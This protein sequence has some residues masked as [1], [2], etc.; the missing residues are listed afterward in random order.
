MDQT[1]F[2][3]QST[4][5]STLSRFLGTSESIF[6]TI[7]MILMM[8][9]ALKL[10]DS[11][12]KMEYWN[13]FNYYWDPFYKYLCQKIFNED[14]KFSKKVIINE[15][16]ENKEINQ[17][18]KAFYWYLSSQIDLK[19]ETPLRYSSS[20]DLCLAENDELL[21]S[22]FNKTLMGNISKSF[23]F[24]GHQINY[25]MGSELITIYGLEKERKRENNIIY[26]DTDYYTGQSMDIIDNLCNHVM[27][28]YA[29]YK[30]G[31][32]WEQKLYL[33]RY[34]RWESSLSRNKRHLKS[35]ILKKDQKERLIED[36]N[37]F[38]CSEDWYNDRD[39]P[40]R[41]GYLLY[42]YPGTGKTSFFKGL[43]NQLNRHIHCLNLNE[44]SSDAELID[45]LKDID[46]QKTILVI[47]D[48]DCLSNLVKDRDESN[49]VI[50]K[51]N[52]QGGHDDMD[53]CPTVTPVPAPIKIE[54]CGTGQSQILD[55]NKTHTSKSKL[56]L[57]GLLNVLDGVFSTDGRIIIMTSNYPEVLDKALIRPGRID[58][59]E[60]FGRCDYF[61]ICQLFKTFYD[62]SGT[63][64]EDKY[65]SLKD[66]QEDKYSPA[67]ITGIF[68]KHRKDPQKSLEELI[69][70]INQDDEFYQFIQ[71]RSNT[72]KSYTNNTLPK[73][74]TCF[75]PMIDNPPYMSAQPN[76]P[77]NPK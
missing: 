64:F 73:R 7:K 19:N 40:Y 49:C 58:V 39:I 76:C 38:I 20:N 48:I 29:K 33:N 53:T 6:D 25:K 67:E 59:K 26:L 62:L 3:L 17:L 16:T 35:L 11:L 63:D 18:Y 13:N 34:G 68:L 69:K 71:S 50:S 2:F 56:T 21:D 22:T 10:I 44:I 9:L 46:Y 23:L 65:P 75:Q 72:G 51:R 42:G 24:D 32:K 74:R 4:I 70:G 66:I 47:E 8:S 77:L 30:S 61:Q 60:Y 14:N 45:L 37:L 52:G 28:E 5:F 27:F 36:I 55:L 41:R 43:S 57:S 1:N 15:I 31:N 54:I 12:N